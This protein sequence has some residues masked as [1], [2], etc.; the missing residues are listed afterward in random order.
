MK[1]PA[2]EDGTD[3]VFRNVGIQQSDAG[4]I[5]KRIYTRFKTRRNYTRLMWA[6]YI[7]EVR[8]EEG[9]RSR[10]CCVGW[11]VWVHGV[12]LLYVMS[13]YHIMILLDGFEQEKV[14]REAKTAGT[15]KQSHR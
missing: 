3:R 6:V 15:V 10:M 8:G 7:G 14:N 11:V 13:R 4:E 2:Y 1:Y 12:L 9:T 5:P